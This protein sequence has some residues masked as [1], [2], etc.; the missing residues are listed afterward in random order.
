MVIILQI[1][2]LIQTFINKLSQANLCFLYYNS[3]DTSTEVI[4]YLCNSKYLI[5][6]YT[7]KR[8]QMERL[9]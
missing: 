6:Q 7:Y 9:P 1:S 8:A 5:C 4:K 2:K 3:K